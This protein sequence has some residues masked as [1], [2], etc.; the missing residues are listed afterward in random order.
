MQKPLLM[1]HRS[2]TKHQREL[3]IQ[4]TEGCHNPYQSEKQRIQGLM[5]PAGLKLGYF[6]CRK[7]ISKGK[8]QLDTHL[9]VELCNCNLLLLKFLITQGHHGHPKLHPSHGNKGLCWG[10]MWHISFVL[11]QRGLRLNYFKAKSS[12]FNFHFL[13]VHLP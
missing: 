10:I 1:T 11:C 3:H 4:L 9:S 2:S 7:K 6:N 5:Q 8:S 12:H 13:S